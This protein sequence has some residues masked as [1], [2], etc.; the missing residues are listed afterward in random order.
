MIQI[1]EVT[2]ILAAVLLNNYFVQFH[3]EYDLIGVEGIEGNGIEIEKYR[4]TDTILATSN[5]LVSSMQGG[6]LFSEYRE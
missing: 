4:Y 5:S 2:P 3:S 6:D 1:A